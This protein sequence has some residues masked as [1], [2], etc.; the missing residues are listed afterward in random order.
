MYMYLSPPPPSFSPSLPPSLPYQSVHKQ[1]CKRC[2][3]QKSFL[4]CLSLE[5]QR[6]CPDLIIGTKNGNIEKA[7][8]SP[9]SLSYL[10]IFLCYLDQWTRSSDRKQKSIGS[11]IKIFV[12]KKLTIPLHLS[13]YW[14]GEKDIK[15]KKKR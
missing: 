7:T 10:R 2:I 9:L 8:T 4:K 3:P 13:W 12:T 6:Q 5:H 1:R 14:R 11:K 15:K